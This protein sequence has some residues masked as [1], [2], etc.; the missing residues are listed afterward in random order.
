MHPPERASN[1]GD[2]SIPHREGQAFPAHAE[3]MRE[4]ASLLATGY[5]RLLLVGPPDPASPQHVATCGRED[6]APK[7]DKELEAARPQSNPL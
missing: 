1:P 2:F 7:S 4:L 5:L 6:S 3:L